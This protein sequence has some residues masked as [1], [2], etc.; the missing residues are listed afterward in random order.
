MHLGIMR[1]G[2][3]GRSRKAIVG[4]CGACLLLCFLV[5]SVLAAPQTGR[6]VVR[7]DLFSVT[8]PTESEGWACGRWGTVVHTTDGGKTWRRQETGTDYVLSSISFV[9][10]KHGWAVGEEGIIIHTGDGGKTWKKQTSPVPF[11][12]M[13]VQFVTPQKGWIVTERTHILGTDDG[14]KNWRVEFKE[15]D[16]ILKAVSFCDPSNGWAVGEYGV[17]YHTKDGGKTWVK[18]AGSLTVSDAT[19]LI[20]AGDQLFGV[21]AIDPQTAWAVGIDGVVVRTTDG[22]QTWKK[23]AVPVPKNPL[24][25]VVASKAGTI[26]IGGKRAFTWSADGGA[27]WKV[28]EFKPAITYGWLY[29]LTRQGTGLVAVGWEGAIYRNDGGKTLTSWQR[30]EY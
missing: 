9:D 1:H 2:G 22:G 24:F 30:A 21:A 28:P 4:V 12:L 19:G 3:S 16:F 7:D 14:G 11:F 15:D 10:Q 23:T 17:I 13:G 27:T 20:E 25:C 6:K 29:G 8:F 26:A 5:L 18:E